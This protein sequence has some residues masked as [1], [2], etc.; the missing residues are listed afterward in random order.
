MDAAR[1]YRIH[2]LKTGQVVALINADGTLSDQGDP[3]AI[4]QLK[5]LLQRELVVRERQFTFGA[6]DD[7]EGYELFPEGSMCF[8]GLITLRPG[9]P[10]Y[11]SAFLDCLPSISTYEARA[12]RE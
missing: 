12:V 9:D 2:D 7:D 3:Q 5:E 4:A 10:Q 6:R 1:T 11:L 8:V